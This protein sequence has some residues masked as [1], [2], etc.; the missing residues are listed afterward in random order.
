MGLKTDI[1][2]RI[3]RYALAAVTL[4][5]TPLFDRAG[6]VK[7]IAITN[8]SANDL[9][10]VNVGGRELMRFRV[11]TVGN[12]RV[13]IMPSLATAFNPNWFDFC[14]DALNLDT[15]IPVPKGITI[16]VASVGGAT[17]DIA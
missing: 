1:G 10:T 6:L 3:Y 2:P 4:S 16:T 8:P 7:R 11:D 12:Q 15:S 13:L 9:W 5:W 17:A 14:R